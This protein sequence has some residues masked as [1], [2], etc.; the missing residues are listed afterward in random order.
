MT[1]YQQRI[2][3]VARDYRYVFYINLSDVVN[4]INP[5]TPRKISWLNDPLVFF[6]LGLLELVEVEHELF[7]FFRYD[8]R[9]GQKVKMLLAI[10]LLHLTDVYSQFIFSCQF[11]TAW[12]MINFLIL[13]ETFIKVVFAVT[14]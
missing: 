8:I 7:K 1:I 13:V 10:T 5:T 9:I 3:D 12:E 11:N 4:K 14:T 2:T 6:T